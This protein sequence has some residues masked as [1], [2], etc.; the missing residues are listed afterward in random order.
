MAAAAR[1]PQ[2]K[3]FKLSWILLGTACCAMP[4]FPDAKAKTKLPQIKGKLLDFVSFPE[5]QGW[6]FW[7]ARESLFL[8]PV[9]LL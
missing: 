4:S 5:I 2:C 6:W 1:V 7:W 3:G 8:P 9:L